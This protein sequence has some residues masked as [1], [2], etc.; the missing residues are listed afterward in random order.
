MIER[1]KDAHYPAESLRHW[2][3][4]GMQSGCWVPLIHRGE[5]IGVLATASRLEGAFSQREAEMLSQLAGAVRAGRE[6]RV[7]V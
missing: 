7:A 2:T 1:L 6:L 3:A 5:A 4:L